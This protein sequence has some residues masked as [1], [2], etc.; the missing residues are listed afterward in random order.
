VPPSEDTSLYAS[1]R[2]NDESFPVKAMQAPARIRPSGKWRGKANNRVND[3]RG[4][5]RMSILGREEVAG[6]V[7]L[8]AELRLV[9]SWYREASARLAWA[10]G[11]GR[12]GKW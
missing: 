8:Q 10:Q 1:F 9:T 6:L 5:R 12:A 11:A 4:R 2:D 7:A 3:E